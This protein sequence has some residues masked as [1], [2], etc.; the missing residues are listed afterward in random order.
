MRYSAARTLYLATLGMCAC[1]M[2]GLGSPV[3]VCPCTLQPDPPFPAPAC[4]PSTHNPHTAQGE[5]YEYLNGQMQGLKLATVCQEAQ[6]PNIGECWNG[7]QA[8]IGTA[9]IMLMGDT[10]TRGCRFCAVGLELSVIGLEVG[11]GGVQL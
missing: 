7:G 6:C 9:T 11:T 3:Q 5:R 10:C 2:C 1:L 4:P 8:G